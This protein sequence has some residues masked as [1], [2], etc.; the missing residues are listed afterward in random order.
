LNNQK[1]KIRFP[2]GAAVAAGARP[3]LRARLNGWGGW[4]QIA[5]LLAAL[6]EPSARRAAIIAAVEESGV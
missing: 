6:F 5:G 2:K 3:I 1:C 4:A